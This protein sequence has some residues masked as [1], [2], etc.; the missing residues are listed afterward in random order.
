L[1]KK[2][3]KK[4]SLIAICYDFDGTLSPR[5][6]QEDTI[7]KEYKIDAN[8]FWREVSRVT[9]NEGYDKA[10]CYLNKLIF[11][12]KFSR[13]PLTEKRLGAL[14]RKL[15]YCPGVKSFFPRL[16]RF[17]KKEARRAGLDVSLEHYIISSGLKSILEKMSVRKY[18]KAIYAC[19]YE[20]GKDKAPIGVKSVVNDA[21]KT[22]CLFRIS[23]GKLKLHED[24][25]ERVRKG[26][27]RIPFSRMIYIGDGDTD[28]PSMAVAKKYGG[29]AVAVYPPG[30]KAKKRTLEIFRAGRAGHVAAADY[31]AGSALDRILKTI[32]KDIIKK[33]Q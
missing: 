14:A 30:K 26:A 8:R 29:Y 16:D 2:L 13:K 18:F 24:V 22:Q 3:K 23:K 6:M 21:M 15:C 25:N 5:N 28:I 7:F 1:P 11:D 27:F 9:K 4:R 17:V 32:L 20:Y 33:A 12:P 10:L 31:T 19:E